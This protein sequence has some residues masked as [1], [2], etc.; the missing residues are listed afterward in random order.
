MKFQGAADTQTSARGGM[1][2][3]WGN[4]ECQD[5][6]TGSEDELTAGAAKCSVTN[7][8]QNTV[9]FKKEGG[10]ERRPITTTYCTVCDVFRLQPIAITRRYKVVSER[11]LV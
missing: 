10:I 7:T 11:K 8:P 6:G 9:K 3:V 2:S 1:F 5:S 4:E